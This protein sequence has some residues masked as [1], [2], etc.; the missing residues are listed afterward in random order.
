MKK[1]LSLS[2][3]VGTPAGTALTGGTVTEMHGLHVNKNG[4]VDLTDE[5]SGG[6]GRTLDANIWLGQA[7]EEYKLSKDIRD[8]ILVPVPSMISGVPNTNGDSVGLKDLTKFN[9]EQGHLAYKTWCGKPMYV[10]H[11][12]KPE[13]I[14]GIILDTYLR[15]IPGFPNKVKLVKLAALDRTRDPALIQRV[16]D[17]ELN[18]YSMGMYFTSYT[19]SICGH[20]AGRGIGKPCAHTKPQQ[21]TRQ[22]GDGRLCYRICHDITGFELSLLVNK[23][24]RSGV[25]G[26]TEGYGDPSYVSAIG[27]HLID[28]RALM[29]R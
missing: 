10:E 26:Y 6:E 13:W 17:R 21:P 22:M 25:N 12:H 7:A 29:I 8:Y 16:I 24:K 15:P 2:F 19:C 23:G 18:T 9:T 11:Q 5:Q 3:S 20:T 27:D 14:R 1:E 4:S 28:P